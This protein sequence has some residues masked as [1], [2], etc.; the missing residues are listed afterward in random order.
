MML[1]SCHYGAGQRAEVQLEY[2]VSVFQLFSFC[3]SQQRSSEGLGLWK[4]LQPTDLLFIATLHSSPLNKSMNI[5]YPYISD[6][7]SQTEK[8]DC[9]IFPVLKNY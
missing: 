3:G 6:R 5:K 9:L 2:H 7:K 1:H 4:T 8:K